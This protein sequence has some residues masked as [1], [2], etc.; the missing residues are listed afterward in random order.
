MRACIQ[1]PTLSADQTAPWTFRASPDVEVLALDALDKLRWSKTALMNEA[2]RR[3]IPII[4]AE[5]AKRLA[6]LSAQSDAVVAAG[7]EDPVKIAAATGVKVAQRANR[8]RSL[9][10]GGPS[11]T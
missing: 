8:R 9:E 6:P 2:L 1:L 11:P 5:Q 10:G 4:L 3:G 7:P